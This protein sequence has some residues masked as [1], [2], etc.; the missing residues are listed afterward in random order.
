MQYMA[1]RVTSV[2]INSLPTENNLVE[3]LL[4]KRNTRRWWACILL[5][6]DVQTPTILTVINWLLLWLTCSV[7]RIDMHRTF[8]F[9]LHSYPLLKLSPIFTIMRAALVLL[10]I[11]AGGCYTNENT[12]LKL[13]QIP[14]W[15]TSL[16]FM[17]Y[18]VL[19]I[20][21]PTCMKLH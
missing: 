13:G 19:E 17:S 14:I 21:K 8:N 5:Q 16:R 20:Q 9:C 3:S 18:M 15:K 7:K 11:A 10:A 6:W 4:R 2:R 12:L 1:Y